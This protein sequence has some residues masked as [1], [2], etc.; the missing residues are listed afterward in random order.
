MHT[1]W[2]NFCAFFSNTL[3]AKRTQI[4]CAYSWSCIII[5]VNRYIFGISFHRSFTTIAKYAQYQ[6]NSFQESLKVNL[7]LGGFYWTYNFYPWAKFIAATTL[8]FFVFNVLVQVVFLCVCICV[9]VCSVCT[10]HYNITIIALM[11]ILGNQHSF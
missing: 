10:W 9:C 7:A 4:Q 6:A 2:H 8:F 11:V 1:M 3:G 5:Y